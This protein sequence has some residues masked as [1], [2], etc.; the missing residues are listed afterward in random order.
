MAM[1]LLPDPRL[2]HKLYRLHCYRQAWERWRDR[3][4]IAQTLV[5]L[6]VKLADADYY[7]ARLVRAVP[8]PDRYDPPASGARVDV[9]TQRTLSRRLDAF[10]FTTYGALD[11]LCQL[12]ARVAEV[13]TDREI[14]FPL[15]ADLLAQE[16]P[17]PE[18]WQTLHL[19]TEDVYRMH[20][21]RELRRLRNL[22]NYRSVLPTPLVCPPPGSDI[23]RYATNYTH[24]EGAVEA[25]LALLLKCA[26]AQQR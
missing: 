8:N 26:P 20:W 11:A 7:R 15:L 9:A 22:I 1:L 4:E 6:G 18:Q 12:I 19:W 25:G 5:F 3:S 17:H 13:K 16:S 23:L 2:P 14:K 10:V 24:V 21:F